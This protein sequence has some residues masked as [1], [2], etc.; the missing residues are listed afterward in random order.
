MQ[1]GDGLPAGDDAVVQSSHTHGRR[2]GEI[3]TIHIDLTTRP[4]TIEVV[5]PAYSLAENRDHLLART[6]RAALAAAD[7][8]GAETIAVPTELSRGPWPLEHCIRVALGTLES[9]P[10][11]V[12]RVLVTATSPAALEAWAES[13]A[14]R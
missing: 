4:P 2:G 13:L 12:R 6:Y 8:I 14:R 9:T 7:S 5:A 10:T 1:L 11:S 3:G